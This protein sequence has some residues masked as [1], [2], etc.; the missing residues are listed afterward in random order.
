[1][2]LPRQPFDILLPIPT[3]VSITLP[4][5]MHRVD[6]RNHLSAYPVSCSL[7]ICI[8]SSRVLI[9][10]KQL[11]F[12]V[13]I[14]KIS[15]IGKLIQK[16]DPSLFL[17]KDLPSR[18]RGMELGRR[19]DITVFI[20]RGRK[21]LAWASKKIWNDSQTAV[22]AKIMKCHCVFGCYQ[23]S[24]ICAVIHWIQKDPLSHRT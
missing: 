13:L 18:N 8:G 4:K 17:P 2:C 21:L 11:T 19:V 9:Y 5:H 20:R 23:R 7:P 12:P 22:T 15:G 3:S 6:S 16:Q 10:I 14:I 24:Y 1:M